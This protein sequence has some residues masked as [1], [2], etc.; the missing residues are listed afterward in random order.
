MTNADVSGIES[1][2]ASSSGNSQT[3]SRAPNDARKAFKPL[4][5]KTLIGQNKDR[6]LRL[7]GA[8]SFKRRDPPAEI[9]RYR[10]Q[11]CLL[12]LYL[13]PPKNSGTAAPMEVAFIEART[14]RGPSAPVAKCLSAIR[15]KFIAKATS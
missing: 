9:W 8:P 14:P 2:N 6:L 5:S 10:D 13:Y 12:D 1:G 4:T 3:T 11:S 15:K 7:L